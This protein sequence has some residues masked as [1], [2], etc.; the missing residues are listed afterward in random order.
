MPYSNQQILDYAKQQG[1]WS[2][3]TGFDQSKLGNIYQDASKYGVGANQLDRAFQLD[4]GTAANYV[5]SQ[6]WA[7]LPQQQQGQPSNPYLQFSPR[8]MGWGQP[9]PTQPAQQAAQYNP[10]TP[11]PAGAQRAPAAPVASSPGAVMPQTAASNPYLQQMA[12]GLAAQSN[13]NLMQNVMPQLTSGAIM[14]G[15][16]GGSRD[17]I[18]RGIAAGNAQAGLDASIANLYGQDYAQRQQLETQLASQNGGLAS[19]QAITNAQIQAARDLAAQGNAIQWGLGTGQL[20]LGYTQAG[21]T[22]NLGQQN[23]G[24][25]YAGLANQAG[26]AGMQNATA[27]RGQDITREGNLGQ[28]GLGYAGLGNQYDIASMGNATTQRGQDY[29]L[30]SNLANTGLGYQTAANNYALGAGQLDLGYQKAL[31]D[32]NLGVGGLGVQYL[33]ADTQRALA[34]ANI[35][36]AGAAGLTGAG[37]G[38]FNAANQAQNQAWNPYTQFNQV[39]SPW[40]ANGGQISATN[41]QSLISSAL[42]GGLTW[43]Q[44]A[45][46]FGG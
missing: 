32:Y 24:L 25:G 20:G 16:Y 18:T 46:L 26:I 42:A 11:A 3:T 8:P 27:Q 34:G 38:Y 45:K 44:I 39:L 41:P 7:A 13:Q 30:Y 2:P 43:A 33:N 31:Q 40:G 4:P 5:Q 36:G 22:Y 12:Q 19:N 35:Y 6:G 21:N 28:I 17:A 29:N 14:A 9:Q 15:G 1:Y 37:T 10:Y 23:L